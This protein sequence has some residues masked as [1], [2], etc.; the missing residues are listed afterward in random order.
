MQKKRP[1]FLNLFQIY[2]P[3]TAVVSILHRISG[4]ALFISL[5]FWLYLFENILSAELN[6]V[7]NFD[8]TNYAQGF[9]GVIYLLSLFGLVYHVLAGVR[10]MILDYSDDHSL[11]KSRC[12]AWLVVVLSIVVFLLLFVYFLSVNFGV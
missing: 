5:P 8:Y 10:H 12:S 11:C 6:N 2:I 4:V 7:Q 9:T 1:V 3:V